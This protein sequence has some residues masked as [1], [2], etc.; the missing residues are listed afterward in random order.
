MNLEYSPEKHDE[1]VRQQALS[2]LSSGFEVSA[3]LDGWFNY[4]DIIN[5]YR[6]D[7]VAR[8]GTHIVIVEVQKGEIDWPKIAAFE[9]YKVQHPDLELKIVH[10]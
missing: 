7:I 2:L 9:H 5:G 8:K 6:P 1:L 10:L 3:R 4:P